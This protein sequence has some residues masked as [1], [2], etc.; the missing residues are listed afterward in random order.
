MQKQRKKIMGIFQCTIG[1][2]CDLRHVATTQ[3]AGEQCAA[4]LG[5]GHLQSEPTTKDLLVKT[6]ILLT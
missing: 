6:V 4:L 3:A 5:I 2:K 1:K